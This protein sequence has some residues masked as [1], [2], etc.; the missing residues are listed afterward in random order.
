MKRTFTLI[1]LLVVIAIIAILAGMLLPALNNSRSKGLSISCLNNQKTIGLAQSA[2][3]GDNDDWI[4]PAAQSATSW[5]SNS[6]H[7]SWWGTLGGLKG[8]TNYGVTLAM[9]GNVIK[10]GGTFDCPAERV[11]FGSAADKHYNQSKYLMNVIG[12]TAI[13]KGGTANANT[14]YIRKTNCINSASSAIFAMDGLAPLA[15]NYVSIANVCYVSF[16][17]GTGGDHR[18]SATDLPYNVTGSANI[19][20]MDG[21]A[22]SQ[23]PNALIVGTSNS[24]VFTNSD[25][26]KCGYN[27]TAGVPLYE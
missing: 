14:N 9:D 1:E 3:S 26:Q 22:Q 4:I 13:A 10:S 12:A 7:H 6:Y 20:Y 8:K 27:R 21:H 24:S 17:H 23:K 19:L 15:Y 2:Y 25:P 5:A 18:T 11:P 16:R